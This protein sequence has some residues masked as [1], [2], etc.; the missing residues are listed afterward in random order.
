MKIF[1]ERRIIKDSGILGSLLKEARIN[2]GMSVEQAAAKTRL[3][4]GYICAIEEGRLDELP[5]GIYRKRYLKEYAE[6]LGIDCERFFIRSEHF[7]ASEKEDKNN[8]FREKSEIHE[9]QIVIPRLIKNLAVGFAVLVCAF[10]LKSQFNTVA[11]PPALAV[12][13]P[14][15]S[16][17]TSERE[18]VVSGSSEPETEISINGK[19]VLSGTDGKFNQPV[20]LRNG[21]N[22]IMVVAKKK[23]GQESTIIKQVLLKDS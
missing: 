17:V 2:A 4:S 10:Y 20:S 5:S 14:P 12:E 11:A 22:T 8:L 16:Y 6:A 1:K 7:I 21:I 9:R 19:K 15:E 13:N 23:H 18:I 3:K